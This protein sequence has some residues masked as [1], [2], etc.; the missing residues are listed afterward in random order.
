MSLTRQQKEEAVKEVEQGMSGATSVVFVAFDGLNVTEVTELRDKL[1][2]SGSRMR[3]IPKRLL[4]LALKNAGIGEYDPQTAEGQV[5]VIWGSDVVAPAK[6][7]YEFAKD[8]AEVIRLVAGVLEGNTLSAE[9]VT[10]LAQLPTRDQ[11]LG[12]LVGVLSGPARGLVTVLS[13]VQRNT[14][15]VL[16]AIKEQKSKANFFFLIS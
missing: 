16:Q 5:A 6:T 10:A 11:L 15:Y 12:Q 4:K 1:Y 13:G 9:E 3:V 2:A 7:L 14:V 8:K